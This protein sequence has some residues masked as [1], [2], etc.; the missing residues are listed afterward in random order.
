[1]AGDPDDIERRLRELTEEVN[2]SRI[3]EPS[4]REREAASK[5]AT[6]QPKGGRRN[7][8][9]RLL[10]AVIVIVV[11]AVCG[12]IGWSKLRHGDTIKPQAAPVSSVNRLLTPSDETG[13]PPDP[14]AGSPANTW[15]SGAA[16]I[17]APTASAHGQFTA[18]QVSAAYATTRELLIAGNLN[19]PTLRGGTPTA[20]ADLLATQQRTYFLAGL[21]KLGVDKQGFPL[22]TRD[23]VTSFAPGST[24]FVTDTVK[25]RGS[26]S[27]SEAK[28]SPSGT[29]VL[30]I[31]VNYL[32][33]YAIEPPGKPTE[34][35][36]AVGHEQ[37]YFD[38][39]QWQGDT[40]NALE[41]WYQA[42]TAVA[43]TQCGTTDGY[44][45]PSFQNATPTKVQPTGAPVNPYSFATR[46]PSDQY[47]CRS[48][49]GT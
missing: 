25:V 26:M 46:A 16:G 33:T 10:T 1:M 29:T 47:I 15:A 35:M 49:T 19:W 20:F 14:F 23:W 42:G 37:G 12:A 21:G 24:T 41:P 17:V 4:A 28:E 43:G 40:A 31:T 11:V 6:K 36:R 13:P 5:Q 39:A 27:A 3:H 22:S 32:F 48:T 44:D 7:H 34:W 30:R 45:H 38:F 2:K 9:S 18:A 8:G